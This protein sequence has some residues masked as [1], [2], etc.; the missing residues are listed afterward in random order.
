MM[1]VNNY[2]RD[3]AGVHENT[4]EAYQHHQSSKSFTSKTEM[5]VQSVIK[6]IEEKGSPFSKSCPTSLQNFVTKVVM[7]E[8]IRR[9]LLNATEMGK[10][11]YIDFRQKRICEKTVKLSEI[12]HRSNLKKHEVH[13]HKTKED[14]Q[15]CHKRT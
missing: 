4:S 13:K 1:A 2:H 7:T 12:I 10:D 3:Y 8:D 5:D 14:Y 6:Y 11:K 15:I 9:S